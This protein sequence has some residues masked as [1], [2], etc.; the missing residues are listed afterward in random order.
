MIKQKLK[1]AREEKGFS[2]KE[3]SDL[4]GMSQTRTAKEKTA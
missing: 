1:H 3:F 2:Q 4:I